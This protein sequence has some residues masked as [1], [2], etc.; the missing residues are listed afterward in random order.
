MFTGRIKRP[1][2]RRKLPK[3]YGRNRKARQVQT[4]LVPERSYR[5]KEKDTGCKFRVIDRGNGRVVLQAM[6]GTGFV[7]ITGQGMAADVR[8]SQQETAASLLLW[9]DML[10]GQCMLL[11]LHT[12]R[13]VGLNPHTGEL[14]GA[15]WPGTLPGKKDGTVF[16]W[17]EIAP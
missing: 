15:D 8:L 9:Q 1:L 5:T 16:S 17:Q 6:N 2:L 3:R 4:M 11:S 12:N 13:F 10:R 7:T 14:Y